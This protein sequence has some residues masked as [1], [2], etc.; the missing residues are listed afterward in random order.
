MPM[1][2]CDGMTKELGQDLMMPIILNIQ[3]FRYCI[4]LH[5]NMLLGLYPDHSKDFYIE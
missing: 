1:V 5:Q 4:A 2:E 3:V